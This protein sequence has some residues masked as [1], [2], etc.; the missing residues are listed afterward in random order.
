MPF[1][2]Y[3]EF[4]KKVARYLDQSVPYEDADMKKW[5]NVTADMRLEP[6]MALLYPDTEGRFYSV[7]DWVFGLEAEVRG[8]GV[9]S[10]FMM[11]LRDSGKGWRNE[12]AL[13]VYEEYCEEA[14]QLVEDLKPVWKTLK[15]THTRW[16]ETAHLPLV[17]AIQ[18][19]NKLHD[20]L[21][22]K[23]EEGE[24]EGQG[25]GQGEGEGQGKEGK[26]KPQEGDDGTPSEGGG[27]GEGGDLDPTDSKSNRSR[28][29]GKKGI[30]LE[31]LE[32]IL[33]GEGKALDPSSAMK[34]DVQNKLPQLPHELYVPNGKG[35]VIRSM[36]KGRK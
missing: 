2:S 8:Q 5:A 13:K 28:E 22:E 17:V 31:D 19:I 3:S 10:D 23:Q 12:K 33:K 35:V 32:K 16:E 18:I 9:P 30:K 11:A 36:F 14:R 1:P 29:G 25:E 4:E 21:K 26:G 24:G 6:G 27:D 7:Q 15:P 34:Q 20:L